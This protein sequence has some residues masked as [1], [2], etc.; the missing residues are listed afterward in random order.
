[1]GKEYIFNPEKRKGDLLIMGAIIG[2]F[3][4]I[5]GVETIRVCG[6]RDEVTA[7]L[8]EAIESGYKFKNDPYV[9]K[10]FGM[11]YTTIM[12]IILAETRR[13]ESNQP[14]WK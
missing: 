10:A 3:G 6:T 2:N 5:D 8:E 7:I 12:Q 4:E 1:M 11:Q 14:K 13:T 9:A